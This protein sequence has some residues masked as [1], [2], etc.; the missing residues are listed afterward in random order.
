MI[1]DSKETDILIQNWYK[2]RQHL[3]TSKDPFSEV[4]KYFLS[5]PRVKVYTDPYDRSTWPTPWELITENEY[6][7]FN[8]ILGICYTIQLT[9][10]FQD[11]TPT[12]TIAVDTNTKAVY[13]MLTINDQVF[14]YLDG[15]WTSTKLLPNSLKIQKKIRMESL[16]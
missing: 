6:C 5:K 15:E 7:P 4:S 8:L 2:F 16:H 9:E 14:G 12:I 13:Y 10:R 1:T 3:E 11:V